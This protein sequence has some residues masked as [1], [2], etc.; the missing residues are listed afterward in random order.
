M[1]PEVVSLMRATL[2]AHPV[3][4]GGGERG[5]PREGREC[6]YTHRDPGVRSSPFLLLCGWEEQSSG[7]LKPLAG[8]CVWGVGGDA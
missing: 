5:C 1:S 2:R 4:G 8:V 6:Q 3:C 7:L